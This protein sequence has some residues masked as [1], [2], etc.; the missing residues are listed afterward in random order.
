[1]NDFLSF[2]KMMTPALVKIIFYFG[3]AGIAVFELVA[4][5]GSAPAGFKVLALIG[6]PLLA[7]LHRVLCEQ[8]IIIFKVHEEL[9]TIAS[10]Q[11]RSSI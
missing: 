6:G 3:L 9:R 8:M 5:F 4:L 1:V 2:D 10:N 7:L 11:Q